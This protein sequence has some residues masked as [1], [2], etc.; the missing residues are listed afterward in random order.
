MYLRMRGYY[1]SRLLLFGSVHAKQLLGG[2]RKVP[3]KY[4]AKINLSNW[5]YFHVDM[6]FS[7]S[8]TLFTI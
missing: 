1:H 4:I 5:M 7:L 3:G 2:K 8:E 6:E